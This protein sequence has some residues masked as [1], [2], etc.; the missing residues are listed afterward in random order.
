MENSPIPNGSSEAPAMVFPLPLVFGA[1]NGD[2]PKT[3]DE[4]PLVMGPLLPLVL[5]SWGRPL[6]ADLLGG[7]AT[8]IRS[9]KSGF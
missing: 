7:G 5:L 8:G 2:D 4:K 9:W 6:T 1:K 3:S